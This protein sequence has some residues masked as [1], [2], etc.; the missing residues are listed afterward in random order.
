ME[1]EQIICHLA[2]YIDMPGRSPYG[3]S[4][5]NGRKDNYIVFFSYCFNQTKIKKTT[6]H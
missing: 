2:V 6:I 4:D 1:K 5:E 3:R